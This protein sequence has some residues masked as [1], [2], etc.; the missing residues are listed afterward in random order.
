MKRLLVCISLIAVCLQM[1]PQTVQATEGGSSYYFPGVSATFGVGIAPEP[2]FMMAEQLLYFNGRAEKAVLRGQVQLELKSNAIYNYVGGFYTYK[3]PVFGGRLQLGAAVPAGFVNVRAGANTNNQSLSV[4][5]AASNLGDTMVSGALYWKKGKFH[6]KLVQSVFMPTGGYTP[7]NMANVS[8]NYWGFDTSFAMTWM[9]PKTG[10]EVSIMPGILFN[11]KNHATDYQSGNEFH[12]DVALNQFLK[13]NFAVGLHGYYYSQLSG[14]G[15]S[16]A[17]LGSFKG[18][19]LGF[20]PAILWMPK[21]GK[22]NLSIV[23][24][25]LRDVSDTHRMHGDYGQFTIGY[26]F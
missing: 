12:V 2:G 11:T 22:G 4:S 18:R 5:D 6:Y 25:W 15:G 23:A 16:G 24:K 13:P 8:R 9:N 10:T 17:K 1:N 20:G 7:G 19:S 21:S 14:D 3:K 26:K